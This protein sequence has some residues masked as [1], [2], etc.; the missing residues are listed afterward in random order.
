MTNKRTTGLK[1]SSPFIGIRNRVENANFH[2]LLASANAKFLVPGG[3]IGLPNAFRT[4]KDGAK[5][6]SPPFS[7]TKLSNDPGMSEPGHIHFR[8]YK[9]RLN[10]TFT[11][12][13][14]VT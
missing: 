6:Y 2:L 4:F 8:F 10:L 9:A 11:P 1:L 12:F 13:D 14:S 5:K 7:A 3:R